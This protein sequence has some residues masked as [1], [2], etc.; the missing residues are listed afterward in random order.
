[1]SFRRDPDSVLDYRWDWT[2]WLD[3]D[4]ITS[5]DVTPPDGITLDSTEATAST[6]TAWLSGGT[7][8]Q[9]YELV[10][11]ITTAQGRTDERTMQ[12]DVRDQ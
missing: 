9:R 5:H 7:T 6:V 8:G 10:C 2:K 12:I 11:R 4:T 3:G 1:M